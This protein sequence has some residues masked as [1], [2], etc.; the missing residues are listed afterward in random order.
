M[1]LNEN[2]RIATEAFDTVVDETITIKFIPNENSKNAREVVKILTE[3]I[4]NAIVC[5]LKEKGKI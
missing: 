2:F 3:E 5:F 4:A 1:S